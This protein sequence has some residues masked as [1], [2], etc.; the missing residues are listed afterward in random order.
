MAFAGLLQKSE[1]LGSHSY[2]NWVMY[3]G[4]MN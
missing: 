1:G 3:D 4:I 2:M